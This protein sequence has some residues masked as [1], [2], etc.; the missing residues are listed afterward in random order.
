MVEDWKARA[1]QAVEEGMSSDL[2][3]IYFNDPVDSEA[4]GIPE[5]Y[6]VIKK[7]MDLG[8]CKA[9]LMR[10]DYKTSRDLLQDVQL[11]WSNCKLFNTPGSDVVE[12]CDVVEQEFK[13]LW[14]RYSLIETHLPS[15]GGGNEESAEEEE[16]EEEE[17]E[18]EEN[19]D[20]DED[21][22]DTE[23]NAKKSASKKRKESESKSKKSKS[24]K[25]KKKKKKQ[26]KKQ[27]ALP[28]SKKP[29]VKHCLKLLRQLMQLQDAEPF[30]TP[31]DAE[32][33][34]LDDYHDRIKNPMDLGTIL[35]VLQGGKIVGWPNIKYKSPLDFKK[36]VQMV[37][38]NCRIY[39]DQPEDNWIIEM[40]DRC[41][42]SFNKLWQEHKFD[43]YYESMTA[44]AE[45]E[46][47]EESSE[48]EE[49]SSEEEEGEGEEEEEV[50]QKS[51]KAKS[52]KKKKG[53]AAAPS[54][55]F[56]NQAT[57]EKKRKG[58]RDMD[59]LP[60]FDS[61]F[62]LTPTPKKKP[63][64]VPVEKVQKKK[65][66]VVID[67][68]LTDEQVRSVFDLKP[69]ARCPVCKVQKKGSCGT[70]TSP[71]R[72]YRR[73]FNNLPFTPLT[74]EDMHK[75]ASMILNRAKNKSATKAPKRTKEEIMRQKLEVQVNRKRS[76]AEKAR[77]KAES[78]VEQAD[79]VK[80]LVLE[81]E[82]HEAEIRRMEQEAND[83][84]EK[85]ARFVDGTTY[86]T[87]PLTIPRKIMDL[88]GYFFGIKS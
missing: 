86:E 12:A 15:V 22:D 67:L 18:D 57:P 56:S 62:A 19:D 11:I 60:D 45:E 49:E 85:K 84:R 29:T 64:M 34:G 40:C 54:D 70:E 74:Y 36:E 10:G 55:P 47:S 88:G 80:D 9:K 17:D 38:Q 43:V 50:K 87:P 68:T 61:D 76:E 24:K 83:D 39:N 73:Q 69:Q 27:P 8:T 13:A 71:L 44:M 28:L 48:E 75:F 41:E 26:K 32:A 72:C 51:K 77:A 58:E 79:L 6:D 63:K 82:K 21:D 52:S 78:A 7:P 23:E 20:D 46:S 59:F 16:E 35:E 65:K 25:K 30:L 42:E 31:V 5:Y 1:K 14:R 2:A 37:W 53:K 4:L 66:P 33:L 3:Q 81:M